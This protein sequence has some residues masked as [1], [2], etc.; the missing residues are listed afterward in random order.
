MDPCDGLE[1]LRPHN[2]LT[3]KS[4]QESLDAWAIEELIGHY[5]NYRKAFAPR[6]P[7][8]AFGLYAVTTRRPRVLAGQ[9]ALEAVKPGVY[10]L[11]VVGRTVTLIILREV[12]PCPRNALWEI[13]SFEAA[14]V[15]AGADTYRW[16]RDD[17][18]PIL[19]QI[20]QRYREVG[21]SMAYTFEDFKRE[22]TREKLAEMTPEERLRG[23]PPEERL[24]GLPPEE[25]LRG[26]SPEELV[27]SLRPEDRLLG[28]SNE[29]LV[30]LKD[31]LERRTSGQ[32]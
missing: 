12:E 23:L 9:V 10:R 18:V 28:L 13:L 21:I 6:E 17:H 29:E 14:K 8:G 20:Y 19:E 11:P 24:R 27:R 7:V 16:R 3:Y 1:D 31:L 32:R 25:R 26:L 30:R 2:L 15:F 5:V 22:W 4:G